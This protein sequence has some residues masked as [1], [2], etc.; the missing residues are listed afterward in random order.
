MPG[1][2]PRITGSDLMAA[3]KR[4]GWR[5][6]RIRGS[7]F[8]LEHPTRAGRP[9]VPVHSGQILAPGLLKD[10]LSDAGMDVDRLRDL[11]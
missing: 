11:L 1:R 7:H 6:A 3:L 9:V 4:D 10:I 2:L 8:M 5:V